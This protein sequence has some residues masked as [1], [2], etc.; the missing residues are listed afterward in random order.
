MLSKGESLIHRIEVLRPL[1][2][3]L[4]PFLSPSV[5]LSNG[6]KG[7]AAREKGIP[8]YTSPALA[9]VMDEA[10]RICHVQ[11][12]PSAGVGPHTID[13]VPYALVTALAKGIPA[14]KIMWDEGHRR[15][16]GVASD[17]VIAV[18][19]PGIGHTTTA[20][21]L[22][23]ERER[24]ALSNLLIGS[25][26]HANIVTHA[27]LYRF[28]LDDPYLPGELFLVRL[29]HGRLKRKLNMAELAKQLD[30]NGGTSGNMRSPFILTHLVEPSQGLNV[31]VSKY[32][33]KGKPVEPYLERK[34]AHLNDASGGGGNP[35]P[36]EPH[37]DK[38]IQFTI[39]SA[40]PRKVEIMAL[41]FV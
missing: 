27:G 1:P 25:G 40:N 37:E 32:R 10:E 2:S 28:S 13:N 19:Q 17:V 35:S 21:K 11:H 5:F 20:H 26:G 33:E 36:I 3:D 9:M 22:E 6:L 16:Y 23:D 4:N 8:T 41:G 31:R 34:L 18:E 12:R 14:R 15:G 39:S 38:S 7:V 29:D 24:A 30:T